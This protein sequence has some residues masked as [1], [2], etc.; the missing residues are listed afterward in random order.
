MA[1]KRLSDLLREEVQKPAEE[2]EDASTPDAPAKNTTPV[3][4]R[5]PRAQAKP[6]RAAAA[7]SAAASRTKAAAPPASQP[8]ADPPVEEA[9]P[10]AAPPSEETTAL[11][12]QVTELQSALTAAQRREDL[13]KRQVLDLET[14]L[15]AEKERS[16][17]LQ[18]KLEQATLQ[19]RPL[20][21]LPDR[22]TPAPAQAAPQT[23]HHSV[24]IMEA[25]L[26]KILH[27]PVLAEAPYVDLTSDDI[28]WMD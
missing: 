10:P 8:S 20:V 6:S 2:S 24:S 22:A 11:T 15:D 12:G 25:E 4:G 17:Q 1:R 18:Q 3:K 14:A 7:K 16:Q 28:G 5:S 27:Q 21:S 19:N 23:N 26:E 13:L 9:A